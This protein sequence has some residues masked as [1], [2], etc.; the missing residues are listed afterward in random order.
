ML[1]FPVDVTTG[2]A[3]KT[4]AVAKDASQSGIAISS[5]VGVVKGARVT[6]TFRVPPDSGPERTISGTV[7]RH[8]HNPDDPNGMWPFRIGIEFDEPIP[9][10]EHLLSQGGAKVVP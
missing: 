2:D 6:L 10:L 8:E 3:Q 4:L 9:E 1:W 5:P 7:A